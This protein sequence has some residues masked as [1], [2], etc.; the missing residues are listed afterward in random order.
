[1]SAFDIFMIIL[2]IIGGLISSAVLA[3][4]FSILSA[5]VLQ[6][7]T[8]L[9]ARFKL[10]Y[11]A[12]YGVSFLS[13]FATFILQV[14]GSLFSYKFEIVKIPW[15]QSIYPP[16]AI[17]YSTYIA[18]ILALLVISVI[19]AVKIEHPETGPIGIWRGS[20]IAFI[21]AGLFILF[22]MSIFGYI[23]FIGP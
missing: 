10:S 20:L 8:H 5:F 17:P 15:E 7:L 16:G 4:I 18:A 2:F 19:Y 22:V 1:M 9:I 12:A 11:Y 13:W 3:A 6:L 14:I 23:A 21:N